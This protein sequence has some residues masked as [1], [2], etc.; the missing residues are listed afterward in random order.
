MQIV[1]MENH[2]EDHSSK[3]YDDNKLAE[4]YLDEY[5]KQ[6]GFY[7]RRIRCTLDPSDNT[8]VKRRT[9]ECTH[10][11]THE[12]QKNI[13]EEDR[14]KRDSEMIGCPWHINLSFPKFSNG[15]WINS[16]ISEHNYEMNPLISE[17]APRF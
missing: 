1:E 8:I 17:I 16:V 15:V 3:E 2:S 10:S 7:F 12:P 5:V 14:R 13:L 9:Y 4:S 6:Q 11:Q